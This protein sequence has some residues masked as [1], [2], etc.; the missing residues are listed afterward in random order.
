MLL[1]WT[2]G[3]YDQTRRY[4]GVTAMWTYTSKP[5]GGIAAVNLTLRPFVEAKTLTSRVAQHSVR[6]TSIW[7]RALRK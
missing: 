4:Y 6:A 7:Y 2:A 5:S 1:E 3:A